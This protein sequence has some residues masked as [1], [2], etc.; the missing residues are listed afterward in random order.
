MQLKAEYERC[1]AALGRA[2]KRVGLNVVAMDS[3]QGYYDLVYVPAVDG[4]P[5]RK[6]RDAEPARRPNGPDRAFPVLIAWT[7]RLE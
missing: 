7:A 6:A 4:V 2:I 3:G 1:W 5:G